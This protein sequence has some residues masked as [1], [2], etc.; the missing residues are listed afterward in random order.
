MANLGLHRPHPFPDGTCAG[1]SIRA[2]GVY[3]TKAIEQPLVVEAAR[4]TF[5]LQMDT[6]YV[7]LLNPVFHTMPLTLNQ[8]GLCLLFPTILFVAVEIKKWVRCRSR[9]SRR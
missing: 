5:A 6:I 8:L 9:F 2:G 4:F 7:P 3:S 1:D